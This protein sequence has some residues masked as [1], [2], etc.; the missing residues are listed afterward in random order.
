MDEE[1]MVAT[2]PNHLSD[3]RQY[4]R[5]YS[6][7]SGPP[8]Y[9]CGS[10]R[11]A[12]GEDSSSIAAATTAVPQS[13]VL[14]FSM[15]RYFLQATRSS[16][17]RSLDGSRH[18]LPKQR[19]PL[20]LQAGGIQQQQQA[21]SNSFATLPTRSRTTSSSTTAAPNNSSGAGEQ[22]QH[23]NN[24]STGAES[25]TTPS[26]PLLVSTRHRRSYRHAQL[27]DVVSRLDPARIAA[28]RAAADANA[29][30]D[31][32]SDSSESSSSSESE[33]ARTTN[34]PTPV[35][36]RGRSPIYDWTCR[37]YS[38]PPSPTS[39]LPALMDKQRSSSS[40]SNTRPQY[41]AQTCVRACSILNVK[42]CDDDRVS[43]SNCD[44][45]A[46]TNLHFIK[47]ENR[48]WSRDD[49]CHIE[50][51]ARSYP[52]HNIF[53][54]NLLENYDER[55]G[56]SSTIDYQLF[57]DHLTT[58][59][60]SR[61][62]EDEMQSKLKKIPNVRIVNVSI[63]D[64]FKRSSLRKRVWQLTR[65]QLELA[66]KY[67]II[68]NSPGISLEPSAAWQLDNLDHLIN[69]IDCEPDASIQLDSDL[70]AS[71]ASCQSF[72]GL[73]MNQIAR[74]GGFFDRRSLL[75]RSLEY[76]CPE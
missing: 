42:L 54:T 39:E 20:H 40:S 71:S 70:Q 21:Y 29:A 47:H 18:F 22:Q 32:N 11:P 28:A 65:D 36:K 62:I 58:M 56:L 2:R 24:N 25:T 1:L 19:S 14:Q 35:A 43:G 9:G 59:V 12:D 55:P 60:P 52:R 37:R 48:S 27:K 8:P 10:N 72:V 63:E 15:A 50:T 76:Y 66:A 26:T 49:Y 16:S 75:K 5:A 33:G 57:F 69:K 73:V 4:L 34:P 31:D 38:R 13:P 6:E 64:F 46:P 3:S 17:L 68:W 61:N 51:V 44:L 7:G 45:G 41:R 67:Q 23:L 30:D 74:D 53:V